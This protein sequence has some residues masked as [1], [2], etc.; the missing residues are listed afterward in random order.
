MDFS[1]MRSKLE[2][3]AYCSVSDLERD[4]DLVISNCLK[5]NSKDTLF[6]K[7]A[8]QLREVGGAVLRH[9]QRQFQSIGLDPSTGMHLADTLNK[10]GFYNCTWDDGESTGGAAE[11]SRSS[12]LHGLNVLQWTFVLVFAFFLNIQTELTQPN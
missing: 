11:V 2:G 5:Y 6:H 8:L 4:F 7:A 9:A 12:L 10:H 3:H 1:T